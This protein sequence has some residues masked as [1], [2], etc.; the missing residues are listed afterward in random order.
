[1]TPGRNLEIKARCRDRA[2]LQAELARLGA[3][4]EGVETQ[5]DIYYSS[6]RGRLKLRLSSRDGATLIAYARSDSETVRPSS[7]VLAPVQDAAALRAALD[8]ALGR[9]GE[10]CKQRHLFLID[11]VRIHLDEVAE[12][13]TFLELEAVVDATHDEGRCHRACE[14][15]LARFG[16]QPSDRLAGAYVDLLG[17]SDPR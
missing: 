7:Y 2:R 6:R 11:N 8:A 14:D 15:L 16:V 5:H 3:R 13:G 12:L 4:D 10:V 17:K 9:A 1:M